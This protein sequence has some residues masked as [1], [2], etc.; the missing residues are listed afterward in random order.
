[1]GLF[2]VSLTMV[3]RCWLASSWLARGRKER[4]RRK[5]CKQ[6]AARLWAIEMALLGLSV[7]KSSWRWVTKDVATALGNSVIGG[8]R[9]IEV[10]G[11]LYTMVRD[12]TDVVSP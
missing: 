1:M 12:V 5:R 10:N 8:T 9:V 11:V 6:L 2:W 4:V 3:L 7:P